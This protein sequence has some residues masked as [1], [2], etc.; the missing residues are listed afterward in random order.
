MCYRIYLK[1]T[2]LFRVKVLEE[3]KLWVNGVDGEDVSSYFH[4]FFKWKV[5]ADSKQIEFLLSNQYM[6]P[7]PSFSRGTVM[8]LK[9]QSGYI[10]HCISTAIAQNRACVFFI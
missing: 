7:I 9:E 6:D 4:I 10:P 2:S 5:S 3:L 8:S 1:S